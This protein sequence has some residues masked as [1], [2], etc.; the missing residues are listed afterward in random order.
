VNGNMQWDWICK[1][2]SRNDLHPIDNNCSK[3]HVIAIIW[4]VDNESEFRIIT[5]IHDGTILGFRY[6][7]HILQ[8]MVL[9]E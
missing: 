3:N 4:F 6:P 9:S 5:C 7:I 8:F 1:Y 2:N